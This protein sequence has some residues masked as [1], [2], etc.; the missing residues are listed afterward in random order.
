MV[1]LIKVKKSDNSD[2]VTIKATIPD[3]A[4]I[5]PG[6]I[7]TLNDKPGSFR[8]AEVISEAECASRY[9]HTPSHSVTGI[10]MTPNADT[11]GM[12]GNDPFITAH[13]NN[14]TGF[15]SSRS[16]SL[17]S[18]FMDALFGVG[19]DGY[20]DSA[21]SDS[22]DNAD[23][24]DSEEDESDDTPENPE[25]VLCK[26]MKEDGSDYVTSKFWSNGNIEVGDA[27]AVD[28]GKH[29]YQVLRCSKVLSKDAFLTKYRNLPKHWASNAN[30]V[31]DCNTT[32]YG[33]SADEVAAFDRRH[34]SVSTAAPT[35]S[36]TPVSTSAVISALT[37]VKQGI[38]SLIASLS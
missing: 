38:E 26:I 6:A 9:T 21:D 17:A 23:V 12:E 34:S 27:F 31:V 29:A 14:G 1:A 4:S 35:A 5:R 3:G 30:A 2:F 7:V 24:D 37:Q 18:A 16:Q 33:M 20:P 8:V 19:D 32:I 22:A 11:Q 36:L 28:E 13:S 10:L 15:Y 25:I